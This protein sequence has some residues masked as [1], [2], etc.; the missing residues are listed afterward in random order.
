MINQKFLLYLVQKYGTPLY[1]IDEE[2]LNRK[3]KYIDQCFSVIPSFLVIAY[4]YKANSLTNITQYMHLHSRWAEIASGLE[5]KLALKSGVNPQRIIFNAPY[6]SDPDITMAI[7]YGC[8]FH[9]DN[10]EEI[11][12][13]NNISMRL[14][15]CVDVGVRVSYPQA[16]NWSRFGFEQGS[17]AQNAIR[18]IIRAKNLNL[19]GLHCHQS[20]I[21]DLEEYRRFLRNLFSLFKSIT[22]DYGV[23][24]Q[25]IDIGSGFPVCFPKPIVEANWNVPDLSEYAQIVKDIW[26]EADFT[27]LQPYLII[28]PGRSCVASCG[29]LLTKITTVKK[30]GDR[31][32]AFTDIAINF[33]PGAEIYKYKIEQISVKNNNCSQLVPYMIC[34]CLCDSLD[35]IDANYS[36]NDLSQ[37]D[38]LRISDVGGYDMARSFVWQIPLPGIIWVSSEKKVKIIRH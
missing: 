30:R 26:I 16:G 8:K 5:L 37:N 31:R 38:V 27:G 19:V 11:R 20:N 33:L 29:S 6:K 13:I 21:I 25:Y 3:I 1:V 34:G 17:D 36:G 9:I 7:N 2:E 15:K 10:I 22:T 18:E 28:E 35:I 32:I 14:S 24:L 23:D 4:P 12:A